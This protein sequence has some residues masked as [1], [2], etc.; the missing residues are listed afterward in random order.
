MK[1]DTYVMRTIPRL[2]QKRP[3]MQSRPANLLIML[4]MR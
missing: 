4:E 2:Y 1:L 3:N